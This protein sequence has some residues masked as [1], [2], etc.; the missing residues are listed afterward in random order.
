M[1][2]YVD[3]RISAARTYLTA[4]LPFLGF[5]SLRL[6]P[7]PAQEH[8]GVPT[9]GV[10]Q[11]GTLVYSEEFVKGLSDPELRGCL[12]HEVLHPGLDFFR[13]LGGRDRLLFNVAHDFAVNQIIKDFI[14]ADKNISGAVS[15]PAGGLQDDKYRQ[16]SAEEIY[17]KLLSKAI[18]IPASGGGPL[19]GDCRPDLSSTQAGQDAARGDQSAEGKI[20]RDW[21]LA[22]ATARQ[23][24]EQLKGRGTLPSGLQ[25]LID[26]MLEPKIAWTAL[27]SRWLGETAGKPDLTYLRPSRRSESVGELLIGRRKTFYPEVTVLW[28]TSGSM[29]G[30]EKRIFPEVAAMCEELDLRLR[31]IIIDAAIHADLEDVTEAQTIAENLKGGGGSDFCPAFHKLDEESNDSVVVAFTDGCIGVPQT[32]PETL[33]ATLWILTESGMD[34]TRGKWGTVLRLDNDLKNGKWE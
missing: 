20:A 8:E 25:I 7:R 17:E 19:A 5:L 32:M 26:E 2:T 27:L 1:S 4:K 28:D 24:H 34:P 12:C 29:T 6:L 3:D 11:D 33:K 10:A 21:Q 9:M 30:E 16:D 23:M 15:L 31:V 18:R 13:R 14:T 22:I